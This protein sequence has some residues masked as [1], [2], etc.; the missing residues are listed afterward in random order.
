LSHALSDFVM[1][2][3]I[4]MLLAHEDYSTRGTWGS[5]RQP[6]GIEKVD[7]D[8]FHYAS[9]NSLTYDQDQPGHVNN[10]KRKTR[11][12]QVPISSCAIVYAVPAP[13]QKTLIKP[14]V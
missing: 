10:G 4:T 5:Y 7:E 13:I 2:C 3:L 11:S 1:L 14:G 6:E 8:A 12:R 9:L